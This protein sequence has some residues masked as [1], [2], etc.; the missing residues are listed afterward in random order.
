MKQSKRER[1]DKIFSDASDVALNGLID[2][3]P[4]LEE[5]ADKYEFSD[6]H[7]KKMNRLFKKAEKIESRGHADAWHTFRRLSFNTAAVI[8]MIFT[9]FTLVAFT[10]PEMR[11]AITNYIVEQNEE[12][13]V[14]NTES[15][16]HN[17]EIIEGTPKYIPEGFEI[18]DYMP[19]ENTIIIRYENNDNRFIHFIRNK[20]DSSV[21]VDN[22]SSE[23]EKTHIHDFVG[24]VCK[25]NNEI[26]VIFHD[27][28]YTY[29][30]V[31][32]IN[33]EEVLIIAESIIE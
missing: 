19:A 10:V 2:E 11:V 7:T 33:E 6:K 29:H 14:I 18:V 20:G 16:M 12:F 26:T 21:T 27:G 9:M 23:F 13:I 30:I 25:K 3:Y 28:T 1:I 5:L 15:N 22:E 8:C 24:Y 31:S 17:G 32:N 4:T